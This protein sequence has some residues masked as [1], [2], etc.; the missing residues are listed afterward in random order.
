MTDTGDVNNSIY[1]AV[2]AAL[3]GSNGDCMTLLPSAT[4]KTAYD[5]AVDNGYVGTLSEWLKYIRAEGSIQAMQQFMTV[6]SDK[7]VAVPD[8]GNIEPL[9]YYRDF[10]HGLELV[11]SQQTGVVNVNGMQVK[12][13]K[14][15]LADALDAAVINGG[16]LADTAVAA[17]AKFTGGVARTQASKNQDSITPYD[18]GV[19]GKFSTQT[20][21]DRFA[22]LAKAKLVYPDAVALTEF[23]DRVAFNAYLKHLIANNVV[24]DWTCEILLDKPLISYAAAKTLSITGDLRLHVPSTVPTRIP[25]CLHLAT[26][27]VKWGTI[28]ISGVSQ[29]SNIGKRKLINGVV[30]GTFTAQDVVLTGE[31][32]NYYIEKITA[33]EILGFACVTGANCHFGDIGIIRGKECGS[34]VPHDSFP[35]LQN[36]NDTF[37]WVS[38]SGL[39]T[40]QRTKIKLTTNNYEEAF[41]SIL[42]RYVLID[43]EPYIIMQRNFS[44]R[45]LDIYPQLPSSI[46]TGKVNF[47]FGGAYAVTSNNSACTKIG[48]LQSIVCGFGLLGDA[49]Y[50]VHINN[51]IT[52][53]NGIATSIGNAGDAVLGYKIGLAYF[54]GN[55]INIVYGWSQESYTALVITQSIAQEVSKIWQMQPYLIN[56]I[57]RNDIGAI[58]TGSVDAGRNI[59]LKAKSIENIL[60]ISVDTTSNSI[61]GNNYTLAFNPKSAQLTHNF[62]KE[63]VFYN[64]FYSPDKT[65]VLTAPTGYTINGEQSISLSFTTGLQTISMMFWVVFNPGGQGVDIKADIIN[66]PPIAKIGASK[67]ASAA[68]P[69]NPLVGDTYYDTTLLA[70]GKPIS[71]NGTSWVDALGATV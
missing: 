22:T 62:S 31:S 36:I 40:N 16:G 53:F 33:T 14:V 15:A 42:G 6:S 69:V 4:G 35:L 56:N 11:Y 65:F 51:L 70:S 50:G 71:W 58:A 37:S 20:L 18:F 13:V 24:T 43:N 52:E 41:G 7:L 46:R 10:L 57:R 25:Y 27:S 55:R 19:I 26:N 12:P 17:T 3:N 48:I 60:N 8:Y 59:T 67:G 39:E 9:S 44:D 49:L 23:A 21:G 64:T 34:A 54:E 30:I 5:L 63:I 2:A 61:V 1:S 28:R 38:D 47:V 66:K 68:R 32:S 29:N 45:T